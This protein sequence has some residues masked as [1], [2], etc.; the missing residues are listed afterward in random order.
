MSEF[1]TGVCNKY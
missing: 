1:K